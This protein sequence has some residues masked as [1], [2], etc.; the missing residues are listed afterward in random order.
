ME[1]PPQKINPRLIQIL[2]FC[3]HLDPAVPL[4]SLNRI[5]GIEVECGASFGTI[6][7][8]RDQGIVGKIRDKIPVFISFGFQS[9]QALNFTQRV[10]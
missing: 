2:T 8:N 3:P 6:D 4:F 5:Q 9:R 10:H 7:E 1:L